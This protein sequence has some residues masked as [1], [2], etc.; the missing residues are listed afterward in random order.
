MLSGPNANKK[1]QQLSDYYINILNSLERTTEM[2][3]VDYYKAR[4]A[5][6]S[7]QKGIFTLWAFTFNNITSKAFSDVYKSQIETKSC[8]DYFDGFPDKQ[9]EQI[10]NDD[11]LSINT[12]Q[13]I[14]T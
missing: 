2:P 7:I 14:V 6:D 3:I 13:G 10:C 11:D 5:R 9:I 1:A 4:F 12:Y 8:T